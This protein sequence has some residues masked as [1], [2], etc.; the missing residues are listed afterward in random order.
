MH[1]CC[2]HPNSRYC[3]WAS[4][5]SIFRKGF[6]QTG[7][8]PAPPDLHS[9][10]WN[11]IEA[12]AEPYHVMLGGNPLHIRENQILSYRELSSSVKLVHGTKASVVTI[13]N[14]LVEL[15]PT[16]SFLAPPP[17]V[18]MSGDIPQT[19]VTCREKPDLP[20]IGI[21][22]GLTNVFQRCVERIFSSQAPSVPL[23]RASITSS[24]SKRPS[25]TQSSIK[26]ENHV[27]RQVR[28]L[29]CKPHPT[30]SLY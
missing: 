18:T 11:C 14:T 5:V 3:Q 4:N 27:A 9:S 20:R 13:W 21:R 6:D 26:E 10:I 17:V 25:R 23:H 22:A 7:R 15:W 19:K 1:T 8:Q 16:L 12:I 29:Y 2:I 30:S 28:E 24:C